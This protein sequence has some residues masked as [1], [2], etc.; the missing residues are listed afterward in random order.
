MELRPKAGTVPS[1]I[2]RILDHAAF[3][4]ETSTDTEICD[5]ECDPLESVNQ[6]IIELHTAEDAPIPSVLWLEYARKVSL[7]TCF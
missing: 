4:T 1:S 2:L 7:P 6:Q 5:E 3:S